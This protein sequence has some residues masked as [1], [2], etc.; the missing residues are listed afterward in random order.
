MPV[1]EWFN[2]TAPSIKNGRVDPSAL[3][4][5]QALESMLVDR[6]L[7]RRPLMQI[8][9]AR[10]CGFDP[11]QLEKCIT[12]TAVAG[13]EDVFA[14]HINDDIVTCPNNGKTITCTPTGRET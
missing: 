4:E 5:V 14:R 7:I 3:S 2:Y 9:T 10:F 6:L 13:H 1:A 12:L 8:G 11:E